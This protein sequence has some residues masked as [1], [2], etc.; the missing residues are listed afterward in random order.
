MGRHDLQYVDRMLRA[1]V[2]KLPSVRSRVVCDH[3]QAAAG[4]ERCKHHGI[5]QIGPECRDG[6]KMQIRLC[7]YGAA[8]EIRVVQHSEMGD[9]H[10]LGYP[11]GSGGID[12]IGQFHLVSRP[13]RIVRR[14][15]RKGPIVEIQTERR[16][17]GGGQVRPPFLLR[18][19]DGNSC[20]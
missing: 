12:H 10:A 6:R 1:I 19:Y 18:Q 8:D 3:V 17:A 11:G 5:A 4:C 13:I 14:L 9:G 15:L 7:L 2:P 20:L 16:R